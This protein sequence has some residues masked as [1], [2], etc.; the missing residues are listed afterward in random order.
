MAKG[1]KISKGKKIAFSLVIVLLLSLFFMGYGFYKRVFYPNVTLEDKN[2]QFIYI[3]TG[4]TFIEVLNILSSHH[5][6]QNQASFEWV[7]EQM[8]YKTQV[9]AGKYLI[10]RNMSNKE[11]VGLLRS[12]KQVPVKVV[13]NSVR[14]KEQFASVISSQLEADS[15]AIMGLLGNKEYLSTFGFNDTNCLSMFIPNTYEFYWNSSAK[16]F[17]GRMAEEYKKFWN[18]NRKEKARQIDLTQ[19]Q[20]SILASIVEQESQKSDERPKIAGVYMNRLRKGW[21]LEADPTLVYAVGDFTIQRVLNIH[22]EVDSPY[23]TYLYAGLP[24]GPI[25]IPAINA[26]DAVLNY[27]RHEYM[28]FCAKEDFS[29]YHSFAKN[30]SEHLLNAKRFQNELNR[31]KIR[32]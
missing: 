14:T 11:L 9:K 22:K 6:L 31:R 13:F 28:F 2:E 25:C 21:K 27:S 15:A 4:A 19:T 12:G 1:K 29:G 5:L 3:P 23:N 8:K 20:V 7:A 18:V 32:S 17:L 16:K 30:Y 24:P 10:R 26:I